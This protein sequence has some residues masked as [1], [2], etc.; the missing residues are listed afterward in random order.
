MM[1]HKETCHSFNQRQDVCEILKIKINLAIARF[2]DWVDARLLKGLERVIVNSSDEFSLHRSIHH[3]KILLMTQFFLQKRMEESLQNKEKIPQH[4]FLKLFQSDSRI[5]VSFIFLDMYQTPREN[6]LKTIQV[7]LPGIL[8]IPKSFFLWHHPEH[9]YLFCY[10]E[11]QKIRGGGL[12]TKE[13]KK[14]ERALRE[15]LHTTPPLT[16][17]V[18]WP[19]NEEES[20]RQVQLLL[21][22]IGDKHD[23]PH[24]SIQFQEQTSTSLEFL[25]HLA[26][27]QSSESLNRSLE[28][29]PDYLDFFCHFH[30][31]FKKP[32]PIEIGAFALKVPSYAFDVRDSINLLYARRYILKYLEAT[33]GVCRDY[34]GGLFEKQQQHFEL[35][36]G[37][38][39][40]KI[41]LFEFFAEKL[42]Y[43]LHPV[44][45]RLMLSF[46][47]AEMIFQAFSSMM[48]GKESTH[49][50]SDQVI[51]VKAS[52]SSDLH[53]L[54]HFCQESKQINCQAQFNL[55]GYHYI[56][57]L[58]PGASRVTSF[59]KSI[60]EKR[61]KTLRI[62]FEEGC[63]ASLNPYYSASDM[64]CRLLSKLLFEGLMRLDSEG[65]PVFAGALHYELSTDKKV[66]TFKLRANYWS[67]GER[68]TAMDYATSLKSALQGHIS[69][70]EIYD[71]IKNG[72]NKR[73]NLIPNDLGIQALDADTLQIELE[74]PDPFFLHQLAQPF[75]FP[76]FGSVQEPRWF[77]G[78]FLLRQ[79]SSEAIW[80]ERNPYFWNA[81]NLFYEE[82]EIRWI[83]DVELIN[84]NFQEGK[85]DWIGD[86][87]NTLSPHCIDRLAEN[88]ELFRQEVSRRFIVCFNTNHPILSSPLIRRALSL[89]IDR[90]SICEEI[91]P[92][93]LP[94]DT[95]ILK[96]EARALFEKGLQSLG[97]VK[98][99]FPP[100]TF[101][102]SHQERREKLAFYLKNTWEKAL[103]IKISLEK[104]E[105]NQFRNRLEKGCFDITGTIQDTHDSNLPKY[106][107]KLEGLSSWN[108]SKWVH[109]HYQSLVEQAHQELDE[110]KRKLLLMEIEHILE[111]EVPFTPLF[112]YTHLY[113]H[114]AQ[115]SGYLIDNE[116]CV[117]FSQSFL[118]NRN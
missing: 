80:L 31:V 64:R 65:N 4:F 67:N 8:E 94:F 111:Q 34:N 107:E 47:D 32:F 76:L 17:A 85:I 90:P 95:Q 23:R 18:F 21:K 51:I 26:R 115:L 53:R 81:E 11:I 13:L 59:I 68:V 118:K 101:S 75:F 87:L 114:T 57:V 20:F 22:Q 62:V 5:C 38:L 100:L 2:P 9:P 97:L 24:V 7:L 40:D 99:T 28:R 43:A 19:Y 86:P 14:V 54:S 16:P 106:Y 77:N 70:P 104:I 6:L 60:A 83:Q 112:K 39:G 44:E 1:N 46:K 93:S 58:G 66:Y 36:R 89:V 35:L 52:K 37:A 108:F 98:E 72:A 116:G 110:E 45:K 84:K 10:L 49:A 48:Q 91:F 41:P 71:I 15:Q 103:G 82:V 79:Q 113:A 88:N 69:H 29:L 102:Y 117:D 78:P 3:L 42:F 33:L 92:M 105:W 50:S 55:G 12:S 63:P 96:D 73:K 56:C 25:I 61:N 109:P 30:R 74:S 27:P